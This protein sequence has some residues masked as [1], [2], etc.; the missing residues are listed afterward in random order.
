MS[1]NA[2]KL[3]LCAALVAVMSSCMA[4]LAFEVYAD[5]FT[6]RHDGYFNNDYESIF[7]ASIGVNFISLVFFM[8]WMVD[9]DGLIIEFV[10]IIVLSLIYG[11]FTYCISVLLLVLLVFF[12]GSGSANIFLTIWGAFYFIILGIIASSP[13]WIVGGLSAVLGSAL[14]YKLILSGNK[15]KE[16]DVILPLMGD[17]DGK[18]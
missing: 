15:T 4:G 13:S 10:P 18:Q 9:E 1:L 2:F 12:F 6:M 3:I 14:A 7:N 5:I 11:F 17:D 8:R 16:A